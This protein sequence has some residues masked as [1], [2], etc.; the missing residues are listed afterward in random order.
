MLRKR[1][2]K[3][4]NVFESKKDG[5]N[6][7]LIAGDA[8]V[9]MDMLKSNWFDVI[10]TSPPY[11]VG[12][13]YGNYWNDSMPQADYEVFALNWIRQTKRVLANDGSFFLVTGG[14][15]SRP[16]MPL[17]YIDRAI[18]CGYAV[19]NIIIWVKAISVKGTN[20]GHIQP[21]NSDRYLSN[22]YE[23]IIHF[24]KMGDVKI[25]RLSI[26]V[27]YTDKSNVNR[28][29][30]EDKRCRGNVWF[31]PYKTRNKQAAHPAEFPSKLAEMCVRLHGKKKTKRILDPFVGVGNT[32]KAALKL[33][34]AFVGI[35]INPQYID[36][37][38]NLL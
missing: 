9:Y 5:K 20:Y 35:D 30:G 18:M 29:R 15:P 10:I 36:V 24:T 22:A 33:K 3:P 28:F 23:L 13:D 11:N 37:C 27:K 6:Y 19:Q 12:K 1:S 26:G 2:D 21:I 25:D 32:M 8:I 38:R 31:I 17:E 7:S 34:K 4:K 16:R 14:I